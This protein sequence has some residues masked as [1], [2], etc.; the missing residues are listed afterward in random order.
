MHLRPGELVLGVAPEILLD[1]ARQLRDGEAPITLD[2]FSRALGAPIDEAEP[3][4]QRM[5]SSGFFAPAAD[6][7]FNRTKKFSQLAAAK[8]SSGLSRPDAESLLQKVIAKA[9]HINAH[10]DDFGC[11][12]DC[13]VVFGSYLTAA[14]TLG[15]LDLGVSV[16]ELARDRERLSVSELHRLM[17]QQSPTG[18]VFTELRLR[19]PKLISVH[20]LREV[21]GLDT[22]Y[23]VVF[24]ETPA[25]S[26]ESSNS[27]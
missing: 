18:R 23:V 26:T 15:D 4:L 7:G 19:K 21:L 10:A 22:P 16:K 12:V 8:I 11:R 9:N 25:I 27:C 20:A 2:A 14:E 5:V 1:C 13:I 17:S 6:G 24:G 3:V